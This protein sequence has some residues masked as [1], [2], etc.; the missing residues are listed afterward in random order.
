MCLL[1]VEYCQHP[2]WKELVAHVQRYKITTMSHACGVGISIMSP[3]LV[4]EG[5]R[6][7]QPAEAKRIGIEFVAR[8]DVKQLKHLQPS[9]GPCSTANQLNTKE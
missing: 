4:L 6:Q 5:S 3:C 9:G 1:L 2:V 8:G 7:H